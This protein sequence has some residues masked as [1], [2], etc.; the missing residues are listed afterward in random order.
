MGEPILCDLCKAPLKPA[1]HYVVRMDVFADPS[2]PETTTE[3]LAKDDLGRTM[4]ELME[5][6]KHL[7]EE[8]LQDQVHRRFEFVLCGKC[9]RAFLANPLGKPRQVKI[10]DN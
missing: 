1:G 10:G 5:E 7:S 2:M 4:A 8:E 3:E 9:H 6:M